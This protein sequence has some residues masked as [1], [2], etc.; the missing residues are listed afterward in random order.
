M[1]KKIFSIILLFVVFSLC[2]TLCFATDNTSLG[3]ELQNSADKSLNTLENAGQGIQNMAENAG[4]GIKGAAQDM[5]NGIQDVAEDIGNGVQNMAEDVGNGME[6]M[7][8]DGYVN[9]TVTGDSNTNSYTA[10]RT[11]ADV[12]GTAMTNTAWVWLI[13]G[14][15]GII[16]IALTWYYVSQDNDRH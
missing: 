10:T 14:I 3:N 13:L 8:Q 11:S 4:N 1:N 7:F 12:T 15:T 9:N 16:I 2:N 5:G 6:S